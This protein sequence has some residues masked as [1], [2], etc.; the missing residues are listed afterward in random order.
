M[1]S[2]RMERYENAYVYGIWFRNQL[3][4]VGSS[5]SPLNK[6][7]YS[8][9][10]H[11]THL[12]KKSVPIHYWIAE[13]VPDMW[14]NPELRIEEITKVPCKDKQ[15]LRRAEGEHIRRLN[16]SCNKVIAG[17]TAKEWYE[18]N[19]EK[20]LEGSK[21]YREAN[22]AKIAEQGKVYREANKAKIVEQGK[23][24]REANKAK[25]A[26]QVKAYREANKA[27]MAERAK[28]YREANKE[29]INA[30]LR[31]RYEANKE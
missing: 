28:A 16:P 25:I 29:K 14:N 26:E 21:N 9:K 8:H 1:I 12:C 2:E 6:R 11:T 17:R 19:R 7:K 4:Y 5:C 23:V 27:K 31:A 18:A 22:K 30:Y 13:N 20:V 10:Q 24:Y 3:L 15:E